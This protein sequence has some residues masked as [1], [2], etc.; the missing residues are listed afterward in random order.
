MRDAEFILSRMQRNGRLLRTYKDGRASGCAAYLE[1][2]AYLIDAFV[3][4]AATFDLRWI[5]EAR[6]WRLTGRFWDGL[7]RF[8]FTAADHEALISRRR[9][10][11]TSRTPRRPAIRSRPTL[12]SG[13]GS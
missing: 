5:K 3:S 11:M 2:Y 12:C 7:R 4:L 13:W 6:G 1:D 9:I 10:S 8:F